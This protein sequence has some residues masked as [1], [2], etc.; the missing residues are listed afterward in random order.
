MSDVED[1]SQ[2]IEPYQPHPQCI[3]TQVLSNRVVLVFTLGEEEFS[4]SAKAA[5][6]ELTQGASLLAQVREE[7]H[8]AVLSFILFI[9]LSGAQ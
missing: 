6:E 2:R 7:D 9:L 3:Q 4:A 8:N 1:S 5:L